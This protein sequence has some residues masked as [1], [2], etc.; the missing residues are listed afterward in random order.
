MAA[1]TGVAGLPFPLLFGVESAVFPFGWFG[2]GVGSEALVGIELREG[3]IGF[4]LVVPSLLDLGP[5]LAP[6]LFA[7]GVEC[8]E[9]GECLF[10]C[11]VFGC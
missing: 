1:P 9:H 6:E 7:D 5:V 3:L 10:A 4:K 11:R 2:R 8:L